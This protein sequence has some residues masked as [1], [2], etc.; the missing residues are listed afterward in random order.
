MLNIIGTI[1]TPS[2]GDVKIFNKLIK[3]NIP[4]EELSLIRQDKVAFVFQSFNLFPNLNV[5]ENVEIPMKIKGELSKE[6]M[7]ALVYARKIWYITITG[8]T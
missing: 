1:D 3:S 4:D 6:D 8:K 2:R 7:D 5:L